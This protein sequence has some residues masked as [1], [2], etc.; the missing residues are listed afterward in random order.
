MSIPND[1]WKLEGI[2]NQ[3]DP[4]LFFPSRDEDGYMGE[5]NPLVAKS[6]CAGCPVRVQCLEYAIGN[7]EQFG[8]WGGL[9]YKE[10]LE[11]R[12]R[13]GVLRGSNKHS[14]SNSA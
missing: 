4:E 8:I 9:S 1:E 11:L 3:V 13:R 12:R 6:I 14:L 2:C 10:R 5:Y 7:N